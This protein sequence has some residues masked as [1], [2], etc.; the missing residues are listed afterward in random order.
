MDERTS[1]KDILNNKIDKFD[2]S[3]INNHVLDL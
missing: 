1:M 3:L 2:D